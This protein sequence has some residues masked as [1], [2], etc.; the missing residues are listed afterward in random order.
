MS[1]SR[2][3]ARRLGLDPDGLALLA[4]MGALSAILF[5]AYT[6]AKV[7][8]DSLFIGEYGALSL[9]YAYIA[10][11]FCSAGYVFL[12]SRVAHAFPRLGARRFNQWT[13]ILLSLALAMALPRAPHVTSGLLYL[14]VSSQAMMLLPHF[15]AMGLDLWDSQRARRLF[16]LLGGCGLVGG[17]AGGAIA[18]ASAKVLPPTGLIWA[19]PA[20]L[21]VVRLLTSGIEGRH[22]EHAASIPAATRDSSW[23]IIR[24]SRYIK[25]LAV[26]LTLSVCISTLVDFQFKIFAQKMYPEPHDLTRFL[27]TF[28]VGLNSVSLLLQFGATGWLLQRLGLGPSTG[29]Q[30]GT[31]L[32]FATW[33]AVTTGGWAVVAMRW[34]QGVAALTL[35]KSSNEIYYAAI[36]P[37][38]RRRIKP[39]L[40]TLIERWSDA[41]VGCILLVVMRLLQIPVGV[42]VG[43]TAMVAAMW[44]FVLFHLDRQYGRAFREALSRRAFDPEDVPES[45]RVPAARQ[46]L[47]EALASGEERRVLVAL[48]FCS[49][50]RHP[51]LA[52]AV[53]ERLADP[54]PAVQA[55]AI[56]AMEGMGLRDPEGTVER[57]TRS[58]DEGV[59]R[60]AVH[61]VIALSPGGL[62]FARRVL[63]GPDD[64]L[65]AEVVE[66]LADRPASAE[67]LF[68]RARI[69]AW[70]ASGR[71]DDLLLAAR[72]LGAIDASFAAEALRVLLEHPDTEVR[73]AALA[74]AARRPRAASLP[75]LLPLL[76]TPG[77]GHEARRAIVPLGD[78]AVPALERLLAGQGGE[79]A[80][81][82]AAGALARIATPRARRALATLVRSPD[83]RLRHLGL[84][85]LARIRLETGRPVLPRSLV[86]RLFLREMR[87]YRACALPAAALRQHAVPELR[88]LGESWRESA[89]RAVE[90]GV[91]ALACWYDPRPLFG[92]LDRLRPD[93]SGDAAPA[94]EYLGRLLPRRVFHAVH[95]VLEQEAQVVPGEDQE[96]ERLAGWIRAAW[97]NGD[98]WL[99]AVAVRASRCVPGFDARLF[100]ADDARETPEAPGREAP[101]AIVRAEIAALGR[102]PVRAAAVGRC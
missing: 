12:E 18:A 43:M 91:Q 10:V 31:V 93:T 24:R 37:H 98:A 70:L 20:L 22:V 6:I 95:R 84:S 1:L 92:V 27:G 99:R 60:A 23:D 45:M 48:R 29:L 65:R 96:G 21:L 33:A 36:R 101:E 15:W 35:G 17:L 64:P 88:L 83:A 51:L 4:R 69:D 34:L 50:A 9:P 81:A 61:H 63:D 66:A 71:P 97:E 67:A 39:A 46:A 80:R 13:A 7:L 89:G 19:L 56:V 25:I 5:G 75:I 78:A 28:Q 2:A 76:E 52:R 41:V 68:D 85:G 58:P 49:L 8:R 30:P 62:A 40:D 11:A 55:G 57:L 44:L 38:E 102:A 74:A 16:P 82:Q 3:F 59:R 73:R 86:H 53:R 100:E 42:I 72:A 32:V 87:D 90:R 77:L 14:W 79:R 47:L 94:L 54:S 26:A